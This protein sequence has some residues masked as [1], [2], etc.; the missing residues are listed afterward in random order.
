M[1]F[2]SLAVIKNNIL[3]N[4]EAAFSI[5]PGYPMD[6]VLMVNNNLINNTEEEI[7]EG[8]D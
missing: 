8:R 3:T 5:N 1:I 7:R 4:N 2:V 6:T